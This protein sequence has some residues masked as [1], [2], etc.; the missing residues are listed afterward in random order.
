MSIRFHSYHPPVH[1]I[2]DGVNHSAIKKTFPYPNIYQPCSTAQLLSIQHLNDFLDRPS[3]CQLHDPLFP[4]EFST[5]GIF[6]PEYQVL[7]CCIAGRVNGE[8][9]Y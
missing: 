7:A 5:V 9:N 1:K 4:G 6:G 8:Q 3:F 2:T